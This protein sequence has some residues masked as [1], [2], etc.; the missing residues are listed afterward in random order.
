ML[1]AIVKAD[2]S[3]TINTPSPRSFFRFLLPSS[4]THFLFFLDA[5]SAST[6]EAPFVCLLC[7]LFPS[8]CFAVETAVFSLQLCAATGACPELREERERERRLCDLSATPVHQG[9]RTRFHVFHWYSE[10]E[11]FP[12]LFRS[13]GTVLLS[14]FGFDPIRSPYGFAFSHPTELRA[15][16]SLFFLSLTS[17]EFRIAHPPHHIVFGDRGAIHRRV[18]EKKEK[19]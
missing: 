15:L 11:V 4:P 1:S 14:A 13:T 8:P 9:N 10:V 3:A 2:S 19:E 12:F 7:V 17:Q 5:R 6:P 18:L 16:P